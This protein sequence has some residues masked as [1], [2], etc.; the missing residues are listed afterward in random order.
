EVHSAT[1]GTFNLSGS[2]TTG[3]AFSLTTPQSSKFSLGEKVDV[4]LT[5]TASGCAAAFTIDK[6]AY[7]YTVQ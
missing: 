4:Q 7:S 1:T 6:P 2:T 5:D 3:G